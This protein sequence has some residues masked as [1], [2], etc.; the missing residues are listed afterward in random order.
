LATYLLGLDIGTTATKAILADTEG[1]ILT[2]QSAPNTLDSPQPG[3]AEENPAEWWENV[4]AV[5]RTITALHPEADIAAVGVSGMVPALV[6]L[7]EAGQPVRPS[8][9]QNDARPHEEIDFFRSKTNANDI[10]A[11]TGSPVTQQS[12]GPK[13]LWLWKHEP[14]TMRRVRYVLGSYDFINFCLTGK[15]C[16]ERNW[17]LESG[18]YDLH[19]QDWDEDLLRLAQAD[20]QWLGPVHAPSDIIGHVTAEAA[21]HTG[22]RPG[23]PVVA[24]SADHVASAF[25]AGLKARGDLL[26]KLGGAGDILFML[27]RLC[28]DPRLFIDYHLIPGQY[29]LNGCMAASG[30]IIKWFRGQFAPASS[31]G[32]L[33]V[34]AEAVPPGSDGLIVL[35]YFLGEKTPIFDPLARGLFFGLTLSHTRGHVFRAILEAISFGFYHHLEVFH[36]LGYEPSEHVMVTNGGAH[37]RLWRQIT[38]DVLGLQLQVIERHPGSS[39]GAMFVAGMGVGAFSDWAQIE[40]FIHIEGIIEPD[41]AVHAVYREQYSLYRQLYEVNRSLFPLLTGTTQGKQPG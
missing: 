38:A 16:L 20:R 34:E 22:L 32:Q 25:S 9:Q 5:C 6:L 12:I 23:T 31:Y 39:L 41:P 19:R 28:T 21:R 29:L 40:R 35:P 11:R 30:S 2:E 7:D 3:W 26:V 14:E 36:E 13:L 17:A 18:L 27:D 4:G 15:A 10:L 24:G 1:R 37:S 33:D 8:I